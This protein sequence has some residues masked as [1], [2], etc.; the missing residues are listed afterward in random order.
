MSFALKEAPFAPPPPPL[1]L[2]RPGEGSAP[3]AAVRDAGDEDDGSAGD[4]PT[5]RR[6]PLL[7]PLTVTTGDGRPVGGAGRLPRS[8]KPMRRAGCAAQQR[9]WLNGD[10]NSEE[11]NG[12]TPTPTLRERCPWY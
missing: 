6:P 10:L 7:L 4:A 8:R 9:C 3:E 11:G 2:P 12:F 5:K 1:T